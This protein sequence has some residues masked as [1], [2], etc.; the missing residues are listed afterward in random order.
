MRAKAR[1]ACV[2]FFGLSSLMSLGAGMGA[3]AQLFEDLIGFAK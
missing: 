3:I 2:H 1:G